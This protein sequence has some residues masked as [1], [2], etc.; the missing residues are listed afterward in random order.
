MLECSKRLLEQGVKGVFCE[1][2]AHWL[3]LI[4][5]LLVETRSRMSSFSYYIILSSESRKWHS[6]SF[7]AVHSNHLHSR[8][9]FLLTF[10]NVDEE[11][12][13]VEV[14]VVMLHFYHQ[15][16]I[17]NMIHISSVGVLELQTGSSAISRVTELGL[18]GVLRN[19]GLYPRQCL[20]RW[21][22]DDDPASACIAVR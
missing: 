16:K 6:A 15:K 9:E 8:L 17:T 2:L 22:P 14:T 21:P 18:T 7:P 5:K 12:F 13:N 4:V 3:L 20:C 19:S 10:R 1:V 11:T